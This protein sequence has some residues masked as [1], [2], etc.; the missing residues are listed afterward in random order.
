VRGAAATCVAAPLFVGLGFPTWMRMPAVLAF[1]CVAPGTAWLTTARGRVEPA[2]VVGVSTAA[3]AVIAQSMLWL[4][5]WWPRAFLYAVAAACLVP[6]ARQVDVSYLQRPDRA[7][8]RGWLE[9][10][11]L[12][13]K[14]IPRTRAVHATL[15][16]LAVL[17]WGASLL[18]ADL[19]RM[20]GVGLLNAMPV[21]Y[22]LAF[23]FLLVGFAIAVTSDELE[24]R[25]L[26]LYV[27]VLIVVIHATTALLYDEPRYAWTYKHIG[28]INLIAA[29]GRVNRVIDIYNNWPSF[30]AA[31]AWLT[32]TSGV[33][34]IAYAGWAQLFFNLWGALAVRFALRGLTRDERLL[35]TATLF[36]VLGNWVGQDYLAPQSFGFVLSVVVLGLCLRC[37]PA[38]RTGLPGGD[39]RPVSRLSRIAAAVLPSRTVQDNP[40]PP[41]LSPRAALVTGGVC[42]LAVV[43]SHQLSPVLLILSVTLF[44]L[45]SRRV[46]FW[47]PAVMAAIEVWWVALAW[48]FVG[49]HFTL[50]EP[51]TA[52]AAA[53]GRDLSTALPGAALS[54]YA[55]A[56]VMAVMATLALI[57]MWRRLRAGKRDV[58]PVCFI[59]APVLA[60]ALQSY[61]GEGPYRAYLFALPWLAFFAAFACSRSRSILGRGRISIAVTPAVGV[62]L[63]FAY[64]GQELANRITSED[65]AAAA[66]YE[67]HAPPGSIR[68]DLAQNAPGRL[69]SRYPLVSLSDPASLLAQPGFAGHRLGPADIPPL[70]DLIQRQRAR[71]AYVL[72]SRGQENYAR[73]NGLL[74]SGSVTSF[75]RAL[76]R[77]AA[78]QL[79]YQRPSVW[80]FQYTTRRATG[81]G[82]PVNQQVKQ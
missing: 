27:L 5:L 55:P 17:A 25:L 34:P 50:I 72:L 8:A 71:P 36:F 16:S 67:Q 53:T 37:A 4:G 73:L 39:H 7:R 20:G 76:E 65:V 68:V 59:A 52:G 15:L 44:A 12:T 11:R 70:I 21:T 82:Q 75:A 46:P 32:R 43:T 35:W 2:L 9:R 69:S 40:A 33:A 58:A 77:S 23:A 28:V 41:P 29:T 6:L 60:V 45:F 47:V 56:A 54:F 48:Q 80:I 64:F 10:L 62:C 14:A 81:A 31:N 57:G 3:A 78:F 22:Y 24:P 1:M 63:L 51:G 74:P 49:T 61:G 38:A 42:F 13:G 19:S 26:G 18:G 30:F 79:V 66:W